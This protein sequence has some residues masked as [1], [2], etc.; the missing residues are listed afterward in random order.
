M[1]FL[2]AAPAPLVVCCV[3]RPP[4]VDRPQRDSRD[5][6]RTSSPPKTT[7]PVVSSRHWAWPLPL[8]AVAIK[9]KCHDSDRAYSKTSNPVGE[10]CVGAMTRI[11]VTGSLQ[12]EPV[13]W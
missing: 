12:S 3:C 7:P 11:G 13:D 9:T 10:E 1:L 8:P 4:A 5:A 2:C 6:T